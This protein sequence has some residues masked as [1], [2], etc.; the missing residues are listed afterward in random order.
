MS[1][2]PIAKDDR[3]VSVD[4]L[5]V[6]V[7]ILMIMGHTVPLAQD[8]YSIGL[9]WSGAL[10]LNQFLRFIIPFFMVLS[11]YFWAAKVHASGNAWKVTRPMIKSITVLFVL[12]SLVY[13]IPFNLADPHGLLG[14]LKRLYWHPVDGFFE[15]GRVHLWF[16]MAMLCSLVISATLV[17]SGRQ[18]WLLP[19]AFALYL[20]GLAG[21]A[22][23]D[24]PM[25]VNLPFNTR[26][27]PFFA[28]LPFAIGHSL[29]RF[30]P[31]GRWAV[32]GVALAALGALIHFSELEQLH[33]DWGIWLMQDYVFGTVIFG[34]GVAM[35]GLSNTRLLRFPKIAALG[36]LVLGV[37][38]SHFVFVDLI[39]PLRPLFA[40]QFVWD[41]VYVGVVFAL[42]LGLTVLL[43]RHPLTRHFVLPTGSFG[44]R[45][46][47]KKARAEEASV[48]LP[49]G[50]AQGPSTIQ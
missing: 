45:R 46:V 41:M 48:S 43:S 13:L 6:F 37:Y 26:N 23:R 15:G 36:P 10:I 14:P 24:T 3:L 33:E 11:G 19:L 7:I 35:V 4:A 16:L 28:L 21:G 31:S 18:R 20:L 42:S 17:A 38:C 34:L 29:Q 12:W 32:H 50:Q 9:G 27:G 47:H 39:W 40:G 30:T 5:R 44:Q 49:G 25:G 22:Y 1:P 2:P 8:A